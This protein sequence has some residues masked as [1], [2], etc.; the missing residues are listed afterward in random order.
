MLPSNENIITLLFKDLTAKYSTN[1]FLRCND[2]LSYWWS[3]NWNDSEIVSTTCHSDHN[4]CQAQLGEQLRTIIYVTS[5][6]TSTAYTSFFRFI[7]KERRLWTLA[8]ESPGQRVT[9]HCRHLSDL[10]AERERNIWVWCIKSSTWKVIVF[11]SDWIL[12]SR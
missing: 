6:M 5:G 4:D 11:H 8:K 12:N 2:S 10:R 1:Q 9:T 3:G 7:R